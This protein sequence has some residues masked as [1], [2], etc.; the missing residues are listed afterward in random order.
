MPAF[1]LAD[2]AG[3]AFDNS[4]IAGK[5]VV[6][7]A[8]HTTCHQTCPLY[9]ALFEQLE[10]QKLPSNVLLAEVTPDPATDVPSV[11]ASYAKSINASWT[12]ATGTP[13]HL[14]QFWKPFAV[15]LA[16][17]HSPR[18]PLALLA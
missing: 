18:S 11:L 9:T 17:A 2:Q 6:I 1:A 8:F 4:A 14:T 15:A 5:D 12:F 3:R 10:K 7:A 16:P 13:D